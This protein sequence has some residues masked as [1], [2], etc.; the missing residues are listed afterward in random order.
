MAV[1]FLDY[2][3]TLKAHEMLF[4]HRFYTGA[5]YFFLLILPLRVV[6]YRKQFRRKHLLMTLLIGLLL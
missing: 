5:W 3:F 6:L 2:G 1:L 4:V